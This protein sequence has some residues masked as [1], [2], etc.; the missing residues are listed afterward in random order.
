MID[1]VKCESQNQREST[2]PA[3]WLQKG[4]RE[5]PGLQIGANPQKR[6][7]QGDEPNHSEDFLTSDP[8]GKSLERCRTP[9][10]R[11]LAPVLD[12]RLPKRLARNPEAVLDFGI[13]GFF[14]VRFFKVGDSKTRLFH[15]PMQDAKVVKIGRVIGGTLFQCI[16]RLFELTG[17]GK[18]GYLVH[19]R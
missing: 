10:H 4:L 1:P 7:T 19:S 6:D 8:V 14:A 3:R 15:P 18:L 5:I 9:I 17:S 2:E 11:A 13:M 12:Q 16:H